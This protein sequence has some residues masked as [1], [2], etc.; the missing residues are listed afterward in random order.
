MAPPKK[1][2]SPETLTK[3]K[4]MI[5]AYP[6]HADLKVLPSN[7]KYPSWTSQARVLRAAIDYAEGLIGLKSCAQLWGVSSTDVHRRIKEAKGNS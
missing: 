6:G 5:A 2:I 4:E 1:Q 3:L 7:Q